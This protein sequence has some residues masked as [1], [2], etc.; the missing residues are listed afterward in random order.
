MFQVTTWL[1]IA[2]WIATFVTLV[3]IGYHVYEGFELRTINYSFSE[4]VSVGNGDLKQ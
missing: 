1:I 3:A 4:H 2:I